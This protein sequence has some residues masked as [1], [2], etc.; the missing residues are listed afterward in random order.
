MG[1]KAAA[2]HLTVPSRL[3]GLVRPS[4]RRGPSDGL[5]VVTLVVLPLLSAALLFGLLFHGSDSKLG[6][7]DIAAFVCAPALACP[8]AVY[9]RTGLWTGIALALSSALLAVVF[10]YIAGVALIFFDYCGGNFPCH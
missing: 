2:D 7:L 8:L 5:V 6:L 10:F 4:E 1:G 3:K 9:Q